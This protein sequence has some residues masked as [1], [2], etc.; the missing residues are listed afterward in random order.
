MDALLHHLQSL[1]N[2][3]LLLLLLLLSMPTAD[4]LMAQPVSMHQVEQVHCSI[5]STMEYHISHHRS[6]HFL[7][8]EIIP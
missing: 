5:L 8:R 2:L 4:K 6:L 3:L 7:H 1:L